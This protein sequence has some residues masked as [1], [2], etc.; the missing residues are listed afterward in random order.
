MGGECSAV[1]TQQSRIWCIVISG[2]EK[3]DRQRSYKDHRSW[4]LPSPYER[5]RDPVRAIYTRTWSYPKESKFGLGIASKS[6]CEVIPGATNFYINLIV[7][8][9]HQLMNQQT[10]LCKRLKSFHFSVSLGQTHEGATCLESCYKSV[11]IP[12]GSRLVF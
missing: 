9:Q 1:Q 6:A 5:V 4:E 8:E 2:L 12:L 10:M 7:D 11:L 3:T